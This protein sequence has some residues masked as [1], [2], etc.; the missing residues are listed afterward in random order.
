MTRG[1]SHSTADAVP[2]S[3]HRPRLLDL[4]CGAG[5]AAIEERFWSHVA[6]AGRD[7]CWEWTASRR[8]NG[9]GQMNVGR[10]PEKAH[11]ISFLIAFGWLP[12]AVLHKCDNPPCV[13]PRHLFGGTQA[14]NMADAARKWRTAGRVTPAVRSTILAMA[15]LGMSHRAIGRQVGVAHSTVGRVIR[16][17]YRAA[18]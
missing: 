11:R 7:D 10:Y 12:D 17:K 5:G 9:Y 2:H 8:Q 1:D 14:D 18:A 3:S 13:N 16:R 6:K 4:F 15:E